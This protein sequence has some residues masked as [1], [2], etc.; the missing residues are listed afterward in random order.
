HAGFHAEAAALPSFVAH[1]FLRK[2]RPGT[3][4]AHVAAQNVKDLRQFIDAES[5]DDLAD[6][7]STGIAGRLEYGPVHF[8]QRFQFDARLFGVVDHGPELVHHE[9]ASVQSAA[10]LFEEHWTAGCQFDEY[11]SWKHDERSE[12][13]QNKAGEHNVENPANKHEGL[14]CRRRTK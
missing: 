12:D 7:G 11:C 10:F 3:D 2:R 4:Q 13:Q 9:L 5:A 1:D 8:V 14:V 6:G